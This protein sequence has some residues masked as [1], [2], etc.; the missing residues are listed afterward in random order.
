MTTVLPSA[1]M[2]LVN[3]Q[4]LTRVE[5][6][7]LLSAM[8]RCSSPQYPT[9]WWFPTGPGPDA[10]PDLDY[11]EVKANERKAKRICATCPMQKLCLSYALLNHE[12]H[13][14]WGGSSERQRRTMRRQQSEVYVEAINVRIYIEHE[15]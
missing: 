4:A 6:L 1:A 8:G 14:I 9:T 2:S 10:P 7:T 11:A 5:A 15:L 13:G 12:V 3:V